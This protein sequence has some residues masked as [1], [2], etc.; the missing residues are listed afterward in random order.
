MRSEQLATLATFFVFADD[1]SERLATPETLDARSGRRTP[2]S[3]GAN[4]KLET[5]YLCKPLPFNDVTS[6]Q[7]QPFL[8]NCQN[9]PKWVDTEWIGTPL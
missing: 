4:R 3:M 7:L 1:N 8:C 5:N 2:L 9:T 6:C